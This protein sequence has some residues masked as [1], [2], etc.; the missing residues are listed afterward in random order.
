MAQMCTKISLYGY[1]AAERQGA[2]YHY[3]DMEKATGNPVSPSEF[4]Q[5]RALEAS[6]V[7]SITDPCVAECH[8]SLAACSSCLKVPAVHHD[9][10]YC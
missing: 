10:E 7:L 2:R 5:A 3:Y 9:Y 6:G 8:Q 4:A 1:F